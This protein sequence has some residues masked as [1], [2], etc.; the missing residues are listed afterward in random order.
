VLR[1][2][3]AVSIEVTAAVRKVEASP[4][5]ENYRLWMLHTPV[6]RSLVDVGAPEVYNRLLL[7][8]PANATSYAD[9]V[10]LF[11]NTADARVLTVGGEDLRQ[12]LDQLEK[13]LKAVRTALDRI[14]DALKNDKQP[15]PE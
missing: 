12:R 1:G 3:K 7:T 6:I 14:G 8:D 9:R 5:E 4:A 15:K 2:G 13:E 11:M 10:R